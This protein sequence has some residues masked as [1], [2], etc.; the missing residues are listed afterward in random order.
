MHSFAEAAATGGGG[1]PLTL[2]TRLTT[3]AAVGS[4]GGV[5]NALDFNV[6]IK[7]TAAHDR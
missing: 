2:L 6:K 7:N 5:V 1:K 3:P 4:V